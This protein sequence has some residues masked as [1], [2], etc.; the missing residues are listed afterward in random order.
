M[1]L[2]EN[3]QIAEKISV[4]GAVEMSAALAASTDVQR[5]FSQHWFQEALGRE[6]SKE[7][8]WSVDQARGAMADKG[9]IVALLMAVVASDSFL[10]V[11]RLDD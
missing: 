6:P 10:H 1:P 7:D 4:D 2:F 5:C 11:K 8:A 3:E 9:S